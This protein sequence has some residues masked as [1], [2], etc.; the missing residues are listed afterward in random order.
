[1]KKEGQ[2]KDNINEEVVDT[3]Q[4]KLVD[5]KYKEG[6]LTKRNP[7]EIA[8]NQ[9]NKEV[10]NKTRVKLTNEERKKRK[11]LKNI[12]GARFTFVDIDSITQAEARKAADNE[13]AEISKSKNI[14][15]RIW[16]GSLF[17]EY[18]RQK[19]YSIAREKIET[20]NNIYAGRDLEAKAHEKATRA[21]TERFM[22]EYREAVGPDEEKNI[23]KSN[24]PEIKKTV[25]GIEELIFKYANNQI[26]ELSFTN[27]KNRIFREI[28]GI[29]EEEKG[30]K[31]YADNL[32]EIAMSVKVALEHG[33]RMEEI[34]MNTDLII[35][36]AKS[37][38]KTEAH[39]NSV[40]KLID[41][42]K[43]TKLGRYI[44]PA[45]LTIATGLA[46]SLSVTLGK[47]VAFRAG[48]IASLG[49]AVGAVGA[50][51]G[52]EESY[53][54]TRE[55]K[56]HNLEMAEGGSFD[57]ED[58]GRSNL[59]KFRHEMVSA[60]DLRKEIEDV[61][62]LKTPNGLRKKLTEEEKDQIL[63]TLAKIEARKKLNYEKK[64]DLISYSGI[65]NVEEENKELIIL[66][67]KAK[68]HMRKI[69][70][71]SPERE[72][73][74][75]Y[76]SKLT[77]AEKIKII[78][79]ENGLDKKDKAF[80]KYKAKKVAKKVLTT[81]STGIALGLIAQEGAALLDDNA[82]S[83]FEGVNNQATEQTP[84]DK[85][86]S[87]ITGEKSSHLIDGTEQAQISASEYISN[88]QEQVTNIIRENWMDN[89][90]SEFDLNELQLKWGGDNGLDNNG[91]ITLHIK[92]MTAGGSF[93]NDVSMDVPKLTEGGVMKV[94]FSLTNETQ[95]HVFEIPI[96]DDGSII[97]DPESEVGRLFFDV[98]DNGQVFFKGRFAEI[99]KTL[100]QNQSGP[101]KV[102]VIST[103][104]GAGNNNIAEVIKTFEEV[105]VDTQVPWFL[106]FLRN[107]GIGPAYFGKETTD[108]TP[109]VNKK[110][111]GE[112]IK[113]R[114]IRV[115]PVIEKEQKNEIKDRRKT[116]SPEESGA[117]TEKGLIES[118]KK[119]EKTNKV[120]PAIEEKREKPEQ[121]ITT[122]DEKAQDNPEKERVEVEK[123][124]K[125][126]TEIFDESG[127]IIFKIV[128]VRNRI[129]LPD[130]LTLA[131]TD[132]QTNQVRSFTR[133]KKDIIKKLKNG[134][135]KINKISENAEI[136]DSE[137]TSFFMK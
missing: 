19:E 93:H 96:N 53:K 95:G 2:P 78:G 81:V 87:L 113:E 94:I 62:K 97:I 1:M 133:N 48:A 82:Q 127:E 41:K 23:L 59:E 119:K 137:D 66:V 74:D 116:D 64:I 122:D 15:K 101:E 105:P 28:N 92:D 80:K 125:A 14:I 102:S 77:E 56:Q 84:L 31:M 25:G 126:G 71:S 37:S 5:Q 110:P 134:E 135:I 40:D 65:D 20:E 123:L 29:K 83:V 32:K 69:L 90:T 118:K 12:K 44:S 47:K 42:L 117:E 115:I 10:K 121:K 112:I 111:N 54:I 99:V 109:L 7:E 36:K 136:Q 72:G 51:A 33:A 73:F 100:S 131:F 24:N 52:V 120:I 38:L 85:I 43:N 35:G 68:R 9:K 26:D 79:G 13:M 21:I 55:R 76:L 45:T 11:A 61:L 50:I 3:E 91:N 27:E 114:T 98:K 70:A 63:S 22:S 39:F 104:V 128:E 17:K 124:I 57:K 4:P 49:L 30:V 16:K 132:K 106:P 86:F 89:N 129:F 58:K 107:K 18:Y 103:L 130:I 88:H 67:E 60:N 46:Y 8:E 6:Q 108:K 34:K 75:S